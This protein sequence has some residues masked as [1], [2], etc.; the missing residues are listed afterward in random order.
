MID[1]GDIHLADLNEEVRRRVLVVSNLR[2]NVAAGRVL[3]A[4]EIFGDI[5]EVALPWR[6]EIEGAVYAVDFVRSIAGDRL[7]DRV[8]RAPATAMARVRRAMLHI[9]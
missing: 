5:D 8:G 4:A 1:A 9:A 6:V 7:L 3:I 2:F